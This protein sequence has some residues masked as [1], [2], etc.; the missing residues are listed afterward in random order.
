MQIVNAIAA[1]VAWFAASKVDDILGKWVA[2][3]TIAFENAA[4]ERAKASYREVMG[5]VQADLEV[6]YGTWDEWRK[7]VGIEWT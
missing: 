5:E 4:T 7:K 2:Y 6:N 3:F 1:L